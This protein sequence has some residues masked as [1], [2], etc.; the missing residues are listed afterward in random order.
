MLYEPSQ[1]SSKQAVSQ[2][3]KIKTEV[4]DFKI[5]IAV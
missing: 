1:A 2:S 4:L 3:Q 5:Q